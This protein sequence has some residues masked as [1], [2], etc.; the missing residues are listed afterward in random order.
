MKFKQYLTEKITK[1]EFEASLSNKNIKAGCEFEFYLDDNNYNSGPSI[2]V[3][4]IEL[5]ERQSNKQIDDINSNMQA[6]YDEIDEYN[7]EMTGLSD[8]T[9]DIQG[10]IDDA[11]SEIDR[12]KEENDN[13]EIDMM[14]EDDDIKIRSQI[15]KNEK[16]IDKLEDIISD[17][18]DEL[19]DV[20]NRMDWI[21]DGDMQEEMWN[22]YE[23]VPSIDDLNYLT[24][25][26]DEFES[27]GVYIEQ[28]R[29]DKYNEKLLYLFENGE[30][31]FTNELFNE[32]FGFYL[33]DM[34]RDVEDNMEPQ[35]PDASYVENELNFPVDIG[36]GWE[37]KEDGSLSEGGME[38]STGIEDLP[39][40]VD[41]IEDVFKWIEDVGYTDS[42]TGFHVHM[43]LG[44]HY[45]LDPLKLILFAE[46]G[47]VYKNFKDRMLN[48]YAVGIKKGHIDKLE[49]FTYSNIVAVAK[50]EKLDKEMNTQKYMGIHLIE[51]EKNHVEFRYM[52]GKDY[53]KKFKQVR[54]VIANYGHY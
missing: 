34:L 5:Y 28:L 10:K 54:E 14:G 43:S 30:I 13:L 19:K 31:P 46:E 53:H 8:R 27:F 47:L 6:Y 42:S 23:P 44:E 9:Y 12:L 7:D 32:F 45:E 25:I 40:L 37:V 22:K 11:E 49:P 3:D 39:D 20:E 2:D 21:D 41:I 16:S 15:Y 48:N 50:K 26:V 4:K 33:N 1:K 17:D 24:D 35:V 36:Y 29:A 51:L 52:G 18:N 38:I